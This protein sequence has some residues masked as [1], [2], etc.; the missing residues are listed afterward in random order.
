M[1]IDRTWFGTLRCVIAACALGVPML[2]ACAKPDVSKNV[3][4]SIHGVNYSANEF[5]YFIADPNNAGNKGGGELIEPYAGGGITCCYTLPRVW[6]PGIKLEIH[7]TH[8]L[9][10]VADGEL[11]EVKK[12]TV[13][14]V[15]RYVDDKAGE[16]WVIRDGDGTMSVVS[17]DYQ[18]DHPKWPW[19]VKGW[20]VPSLAYQ[21]ERWEL[22]RKHEQDGID[23]YKSM[24]E[25][26][27]VDPKK[28]AEESWD[29]A[30]EYDKDSIKGFSGP[31]DP[32]YLTK[33]KKGNEDGLRRS[34][35]LLERV[36]KA[37]P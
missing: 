4:V 18:P 35:E 28:H 3:P 8:M 17:S 23:L 10:A 12:T 22:Y 5:T 27:R 6:R 25:E 21:R 1:L 29:V 31:S 13:V 11:R 19:K 14:D 24:L 37:K 9:V 32:S 20:P 16:L 15:P 30:K 33:L 34:Y 7:S 2:V 36:M 26:L